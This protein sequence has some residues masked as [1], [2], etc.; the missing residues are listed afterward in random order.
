MPRG[1]IRSKAQ[2]LFWA[3]SRQNGWP[4]SRIQHIVEPRRDFIQNNAL[5]VINLDV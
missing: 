2:G 1:G 4:E 5:K 3:I